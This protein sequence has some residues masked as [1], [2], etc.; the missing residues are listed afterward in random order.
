[1]VKNSMM[2]RSLSSTQNLFFFRWSVLRFS[3]SYIP[4][5]LFLKANAGPNTNGSQFFITVAPTPHLDGKHVVFG[6]VIKGK[7]IVRKIERYPTKGE[8]P[9]SPVVIADC[10]EISWDDPSLKEDADAAAAAAEDPYEDY[11]VDEDRDTENP[12]VALEI[13]KVVRDVGNKLFK[14]GKTEEAL[15]KYE[16][17]FSTVFLF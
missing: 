15:N 3:L 11:P 13:A 4:D 7:A 16:S 1:M 10:G 9:T 12:E 17:E 2:R 5:S 6:E 8:V 14:E